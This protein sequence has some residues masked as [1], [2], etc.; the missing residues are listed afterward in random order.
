MLTESAW[1]WGAIPIIF[2][3]LVALRTGSYAVFN[4]TAFRWLDE[5]EIRL[6]GRAG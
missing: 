1:S 3:A 5:G 6:A 4:V 2:V